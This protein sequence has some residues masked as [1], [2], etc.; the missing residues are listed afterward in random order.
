MNRLEKRCC[1]LTV[2][3]AEEVGDREGAEGAGEGL[4]AAAAMIVG[5]RELEAAV[6]PID[7]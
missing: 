2:S 4:S 1:S 7:C 5:A 3:A 6:W